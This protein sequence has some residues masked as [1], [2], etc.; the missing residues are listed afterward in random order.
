MGGV[1]RI[2]SRLVC[3]VPHATVAVTHD[4][5]WCSVIHD[6]SLDILAAKLL[7]P[8]FDRASLVSQMKMF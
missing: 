1:M 7:A 2:S 8:T 3:Q 4:D 6:V 5:D